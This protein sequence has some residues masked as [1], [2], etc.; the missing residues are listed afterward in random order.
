MSFVVSFHG[1]EHKCGTTMISQCVAE[2]VSQLAPDL[3]VILLHPQGRWGTEYSPMTGETM[4]TI[5][6][7]LAE[8]LLEPEE[9][10]GRVR[11]RGNLHVIG[12]A[13]ETGSIFSYHPD[14]GKYLIETLQ[15]SVDLIICD[16]GCDIEHGLCLGTMLI[17]D[18]IYIVMDQRE[19]TVA[20]YENNVALHEKLGLAPFAY[21]VNEYDKGSPYNVRY[22]AERLN[23]DKERFRKIRSSDYGLQAEIDG[24]S[25]VSY[26]GKGF[27]RDIDAL[28]KELCMALTE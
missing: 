1:A 16:S 20:F 19:R 10:L 14:M 25:L 6:H 18:R 24:K 12:G 8:K 3:K 13:G 21:V 23:S 11:W 5:K 15:N 17:S 26:Q 22:L 27:V 2:R 28:A 4:E 7:Y 9:L